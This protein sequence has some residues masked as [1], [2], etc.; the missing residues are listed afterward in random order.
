[1][2]DIV[3]HRSC[4]LSSNKQLHL[5][6]QRIFYSAWLFERILNDRREEWP[7]YLENAKGASKT[8]NELRGGWHAIIDRKKKATADI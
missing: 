4:W 3:C 6:K 5:L 1:M 2:F 7:T 8:A